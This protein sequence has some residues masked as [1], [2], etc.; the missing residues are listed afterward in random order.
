MKQHL[1]W[2]DM[3]LPKAYA[4]NNTLPEQY[5]DRVAYCGYNNV[6]DVFCLVARDYRIDTHQFV[7]TY[8]EQIYYALNSWRTLA[9]NPRIPVDLVE[10]SSLKMEFPFEASQRL[11]ALT[12]A[13]LYSELVFQEHLLH[14]EEFKV[15]T[16]P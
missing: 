15:I 10:M 1:V 8:E 14:S 11:L 4:R 12:Y 9:P 13:R 3:P 7:T 5:I 6:M 16:L 2:L